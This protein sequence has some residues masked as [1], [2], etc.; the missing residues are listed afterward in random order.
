MPSRK[1]IAT[2]GVAGLA[3]FVLLTVPGSATQEIVG[4]IL[5]AGMLI[6]VIGLVVA[7]LGPESQP[8]R[9]REQQAREEFDRT[10]S[11]PSE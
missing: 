11:W 2:V 8:E 1:W 6:C 3:G 9:E 5:L 7:R 4:T 10:G